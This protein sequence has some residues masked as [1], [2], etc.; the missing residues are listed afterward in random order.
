[1]TRIERGM[2]SDFIAGVIIGAVGAAVIAWWI[3]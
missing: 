2:L 1:M 3:G